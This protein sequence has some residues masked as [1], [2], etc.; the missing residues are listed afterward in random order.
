LGRPL[1]IERIGTLDVNK[2]WTITTEE[3]MMKE[4]ACTFEV[5]F[6]LRYPSCSQVFGKRIETSTSVI[7]MTN[8]S[9][10]SI[11]SKVYSL[12]KTAAA[13]TSDN[14]PENMG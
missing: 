4:F 10:G 9:I 13:L 3:R 11:N 14:Y 12:L 2:L 5:L 1:Y 6:S 7:D 8:G